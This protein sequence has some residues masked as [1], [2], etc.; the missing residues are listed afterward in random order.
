MH[1]ERWY[2]KPP[3]QVF[4]EIGSTP[5]GL[6]IK[7]AAHRLKKFGYNEFE[8][9]EHDSLP[10]VF[11]SQFKSTIIL[12]LLAAAAISFLL[13]DVLEAQIILLIL[14]INAAIGT[15]HEY[16]AQNALKALKKLQTNYVNAIREG[17]EMIIPARE[18]VP[19]DIII[20]RA[21]DKVPADGRI[22][23][24]ASLMANESTLTGESRTISKQTEKLSG[25]KPL[26][27]RINMAFSGTFISSGRG[28][29]L[30][31]ETNGNTQIGAIYKGVSGEKELFPLQIKIN[32]FSSNL[33]K[34]AIVAITL[35]L[36]FFTFVLGPDFGYGFHMVLELSLAQA[37]SFIP[38]GLPIVITIAL[39]L[40][41]SQM[42]KKNAI[43]RKLQA[44]ETIGGVDVLCVDKTGTLTINKMSVS[45]LVLS[46]RHY[47]ASGS[48][49]LKCN[50][51]KMHA[52]DEK[53]LLPL[54][55]AGILCN[56]SSYDSSSKKRIG[57]PI[58][59]ALVDY[60][61]HF[62][63]DKTKYSSAHPR[64]GEIQF[65]PKNKYMV[66]ANKFGKKF[67]FHAKGAPEAILNFCT[68]TL[69]N[70]KRRKMRASDRMKIKKFTTN[71]ARRGLRVLA[72]AQKADEKKVARLTSGYT[73]LGLVG[74]EDPI[75]PDVKATIQK[76][77][78]AGVKVIMITGDHRLTAASIA[79]QAGI[80]TTGKEGVLEGSQIEKMSSAQLRKIIGDVSVF[81]RVTGE[82]KAKIVNALKAR[83]HI[84]AMTGDGVNDAIALKDAHVGI[85]LGSA[86]DVA[87]EASDVVLSD[88][89][90]ASIVDA[91]E[92]GRR[93]SI[94]IRKVVKY[95]FATN[96][97]EILFLV[98]II[99]SPLWAGSMLPLA[100][101]PIHIIYVNLVTD[102]FLDVSLATE[103]REKGLMKQKP[104]AFS[105]SLF[106]HDVHRFIAISSAIMAVGMFAAYIYYMKV[107]IPLLQKQ[108]VFFTLLAFFQIWSAQNARSLEKSVF[109]LGIFSNKYLA[110]ATILSILL[111]LF[112]IYSPIANDFLKTHPISLFD[113]AIILGVSAPI[114]I[115]FELLKA[116]QRRGHAVLS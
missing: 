14:L 25:K 71:M 56:D 79:K 13:D 22:I 8:E 34:A 42:A 89:H 26:A 85:S 48:P 83:G 59:I 92:E 50:G 17:R 108:T 57:E 3:A 30:V 16:N 9:K 64:A 69:E 104:K 20:L 11:A 43:T 36:L 103:P 82:H 88:D 77:N 78:D 96:L 111:Q 31:T 109:E 113:W 115:I 94:N 44:I 67:S 98:A 37:V 101:L 62:S 91:I 80:L 112:A 63:L 2:N 110:G 73:F 35:F 40:G 58:E 105:Q 39:A 41:V 95:L 46:N 6:S 49:Y 76:A 114:F 81:A 53:G 5:K 18:A 12:I 45:E 33:G 102:G 60:A 68:H 70:N 66:T 86:T 100:L 90:V 75:R 65:E 10:K 116:L 97:T 29:L 106:S 55:E 24:C 47:C 107:D 61:R 4:S 51:K 52:L 7:E 38:E 93:S 99:L 1:S 21:G 32:K 23:E 72:F 87:K 74:F 19:G 54:L 27:E 28:L 15:Y 84:V